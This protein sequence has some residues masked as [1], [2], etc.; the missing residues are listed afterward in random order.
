M[1]DLTQFLFEVAGAGIIVALTA[2][3]ALVASWAIGRIMSRGS[4]QLGLAARRVGIFVVGL[5]GAVLLIQYVGVSA[6]ILLLLVG[7]FGAAALVACR[8]ALENLGGK[9]FSNVYVPFK[10][11][12]RIEISG[13]SGQVIEINSMCTVLLSADNQLASIPNSRFLEEVL[14]NV[15]P[16]AWREL[17]V[18]LTLT[19][20]VDLAAFES[21][22]LKSLAK[23]RLR[24]DPRFPP[25][26]STRSRDA[27][28]TDMVL[29]VMIRRPEDRDAI[30]ADV[31]RR[32]TVAMEK[33]QGERKARAAAPPATVPEK[34]APTLDAAQ[35][36]DGR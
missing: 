30:L 36:R 26:L 29:T 34:V 14:V 22:V 35:R 20:G 5:I 17:A 25:V 24:L 6:D 9:Y 2:A 31:N 28:S 13:H 15:T 3:V 8:G 4:P 18:P 21:E 32:V 11:G 27:Q 12:D 19:A 7:L 33:V 23:I 16:Q 10:V 1:I